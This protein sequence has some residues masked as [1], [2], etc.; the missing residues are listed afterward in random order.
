MAMLG[1]FVTSLPR[2]K[3]TL[4]SRAENIESA[5]LHCV[6][7]HSTLCLTLCNSIDGSLPGFPVHH[8]LLELAQTHVHQVSDTIQPSN[9]LSSPSPP[10]FNFSQ[11]QGLFQ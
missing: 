3:S 1:G 7:S 10:A 9:P 11:H 8:P 2:P 6:L 4:G 5:S